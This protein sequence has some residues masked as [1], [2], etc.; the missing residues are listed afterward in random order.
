VSRVIYRQEHG[1]ESENVDVFSG[2]VR[3]G[4]GMFSGYFDVEDANGVWSGIVGKFA[5]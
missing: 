3:E 1:L 2:D 5:I 4:L